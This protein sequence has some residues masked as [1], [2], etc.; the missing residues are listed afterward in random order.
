MAIRTNAHYDSVAARDEYLAFHYPD[1]DPL[2]ALLGDTAPPLE[3][4]YP[5]V[6]PSFW[7][8]DPEGRAL[9]VGAA[10]GRVTF[11]L[12]LDHKIAWG[13]DL[14]RALLYAARAVQE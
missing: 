2:R 5:F 4:R 3:H 9:D 12:A 8:G 7:D 6:L 11:A 10:C 1:G 14:A 13:L